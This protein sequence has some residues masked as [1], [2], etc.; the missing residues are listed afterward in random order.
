[1]MN[2]R[3][4][5]GF[6]AAAPV[7]AAFAPEVWTSWDLGVNPAKV[8]AWAHVREHMLPSE[9]N[10]TCRRMLVCVHDYTD[11]VRLFDQRG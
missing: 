2:R 8:M 3:R 9:V 10:D 4:L 6:L 5:F 7:A 11:Q 1:M